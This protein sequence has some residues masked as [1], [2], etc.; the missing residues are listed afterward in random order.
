[1]QLLSHSRHALGRDVAEMGWGA[2]SRI[3]LKNT[4]VHR[5]VVDL[6]ARCDEHIIGVKDNNGDVDSPIAV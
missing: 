3:G 6:T 5:T 4:M 2:D 1:M